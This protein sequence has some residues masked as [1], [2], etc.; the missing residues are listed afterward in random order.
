MAYVLFFL[1][2]IIVENFIPIPKNFNVFLFVRAKISFDNSSVHWSKFSLLPLFNILR[3][4]IAIR[5][6]SL[7]IGLDLRRKA[8]T[9]GI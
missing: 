8:I 3:R 2:K 5:A 4:R 6:I 7:P 9:Y 1:L